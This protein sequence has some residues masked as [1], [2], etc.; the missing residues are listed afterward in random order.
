MSTPTKTELDGFRTDAAA[1]FA[2]HI[3][4]PPDFMMP[5]TFMEVGT[6]AQFHFLVEWQRKEI[7]RAHV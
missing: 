6:D 5:L 7:G 4:P 1:W 2:E 3:P